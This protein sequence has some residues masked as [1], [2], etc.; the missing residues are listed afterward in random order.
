[1]NPSK[2]FL[3]MDEV[4]AGGNCK[5][6]ADRNLSL[7]QILGDCVTKQFELLKSVQPGAEIFIWSDMF[8]PNHNAG[9]RHYLVEGDFNNSWEYIPKELVVVCWNYS[10]RNKS[11]RHFSKNGFPVMAA[12]Y[13]DADDLENPM[14]WLNSLEKI[15][16][17]KGII[18]TSWQNKYELL[19]PFGKLVA[20]EKV[21]EKK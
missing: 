6:C 11:L 17:V 14:G 2:Y 19:A 10:I 16:N 8:D 15:K 21:K 7:A 18:Y 1:M 9:K 12:A 20:P 5:A 4:R 3:G 13:Y